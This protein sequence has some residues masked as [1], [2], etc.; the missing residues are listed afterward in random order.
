MGLDM[1]ACSVDKE[2]H[3]V[4]LD[5]ELPESTYFWRKHTKL[6]QFMNDYYF[7]LVEDGEI[8]EPE[9]AAEDKPFGTFNCVPLYLPMGK[10][11]ELD[12]LVRH[13]ELPESDGGFFWGHQ[14][15]DETAA[16]NKQQD[17]AFCKWAMNETDKGNYIYYSCWF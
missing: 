12:E 10:I 7:Q 6:H 3:P 4:K 13:E 5:Q 2:D 17:I 11:R 8:K 1:Y 15:Q 16:D 14:W 9:N